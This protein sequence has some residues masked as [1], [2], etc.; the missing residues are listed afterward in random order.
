MSQKIA[1]LFTWRSALS[2]SAGPKSAVTRHILLAI[3]LYMSEKGEGAFPSME[4][5]ADDTGL[6]V[7][8][9]KKHVPLAEELGWLKVIKK[10]GRG[11]GWKRNDYKAT[12][13]DNYYQKMEEIEAKAVQEVHDEGGE[14]DAPPSENV[15]N[16][17]H[18]RGESERKNVVNEVHPNTPYNSSMNTPESRARGT[19]IKTLAG[20]PPPE[21]AF[22]LFEKEGFAEAYLDYRVYLK[23]TSN[24]WP[25]AV[26]V[27]R[28]YVKLHN[29]MRAG[30]DPI[31]VIWQTIDA[32]AKSF[33][34][35]RNFESKSK[36]YGTDR[37][38]KGD[39]HAEALTEI[40][41]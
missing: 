18:E 33:F 17:V 10:R 15:V 11:Q 29:L 12:I 23:E 22:E 38:S 39:K 41:R 27:Q 5:L 9:I 7:R 8:S 26:E 30:N 2:S 32:K 31:D 16:V 20:I 4:R 36:K 25:S 34:P 13:P 3:S 40:L 21:I 37:K 14:Y 35:I 6:S 19:I 1:P 28:D 24:R